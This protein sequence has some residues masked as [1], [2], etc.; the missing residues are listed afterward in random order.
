MAR[1]QT[2][3][4]AHWSEPFC[5]SYASLQQDQKK[6]AD[7][8]ILALIKNEITGGMRVKPIQPDK[9]YFEA[10]INDGDRLIFRENDNTIWFIDVVV[11]DDIARYSNKPKNK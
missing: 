10:R 5:E 8:V 4:S 6:G 1:K 7:K 3:R 2:F 9:Y 11:H